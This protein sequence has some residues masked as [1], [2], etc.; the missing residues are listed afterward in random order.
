MNKIKILIVEDNAIIS[1]ELKNTLEKLNYIVTDRVKKEC[2][3]LKS[4]QKNEPNIILMDIE[5]GQK[6]NGIEIVEEI[7][8]IKKIPVIYL[9]G[10]KK[11]EMVNKALETNPAYY[12]TKPFNQIQLNSAIQLVIKN[13]CENTQD[14]ESLGYEYSFDVK[15]KKLFY[16][17][18]I[19]KLASKETQLLDLLVEAKGQVVLFETIENIIWANQPV[20]NDALRVL[21]SR[22][23]KKIHNDLIESV[24]S[25]GFRING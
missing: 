21:V 11:Q 22:L 4:I 18:E 19:Q 6:K 13:F 1:L 20:S 16:K 14:F 17:D 3:I 23:R 5:L 8:K 7:Y 10:I 24:Y 9:S 25:H 2:D 12:L 15:N